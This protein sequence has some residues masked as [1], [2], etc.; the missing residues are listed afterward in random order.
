M[1]HKLK[2]NLPTI[3]ILL[4]FC[5]YVYLAIQNTLSI[6]VVSLILFIYMSILKQS[7]FETS[8]RSVA[9]NVISILTGTGY[10][11]KD[12]DQW[13]N[14]PLIFF[15][16]RMLILLCIIVSFLYTGPTIT[17]SHRTIQYQMFSTR[18]YNI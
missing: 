3:E 9:F 6:A 7:L 18:I 11:T 10:V 4:G 8:L 5:I 17:Q 14:F 13:G 15:L 2:E 1:S 12:F 16:I